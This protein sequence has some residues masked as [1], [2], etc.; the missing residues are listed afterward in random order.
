[1]FRNATKMSEE[2]RAEVKMS[3]ERRESTKMCEEKRARTKMSESKRVKR[4]RLQRWVNKVLLQGV[5]M[6][7]LDLL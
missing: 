4:Q 3:E 2:K 1:M 5:I 6:T 7:K